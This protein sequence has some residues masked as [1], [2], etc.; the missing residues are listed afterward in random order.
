MTSSSASRSPHNQLL[1]AS[2]SHRSCSTPPSTHIPNPFTVVCWNACSLLAR[3]PAVQLYL[4]EYHPSIL[5]ILEPHIH[6]TNRIPLFPHYN[7]THQPHPRGHAT[8]GIVMYIHTS[9]TAA[10]YNVIPHAFTHDTSSFIL[11]YQISSPVLNRPF[12]LMPVYMSS[13]ATAADWINVKCAVDTAR[14]GLTEAMDIPFLLIGDMNARHPSWDPSCGHDINTSNTNGRHLHDTITGDHDWHLLNNDLS[15]PTPTHHHT[16]PP[17]TATII[18]LAITNNIGLFNHFHVDDGSTL[19]SDHRAIIVTVASRSHPTSLPTRYVWRTHDNDVPWMLFQLEL[20]ELLQTWRQRWEPMLSHTTPFTQ[21]DADNCWTQLRDMI[22]HAAHTTIGKKAIRHTSKHWFTIN[23]AIPG[24]YRTYI[25]LRRARDRI[26][27][28]NRPVP[29]HL[30]AQVRTARHTFR[31]AMRTAKQKCWE[32]L[33]EQVDRNHQ[34]IWTAWHRTT[35]ST[36]TP[37]PTFQPTANTQPP[38]SPVA[39]LN[40]LAQ[41]FQS[42]STLPNDPAFNRSQDDAVHNTVTSAQLPPVHVELPFTQQQLTDACE[43]INTN[44]ALGPDDISPCF[45]K[46]GGPALMSALFL[47][48]HICYQHGVLPSQWT[49]GLVIAL[50]KHKGDKHD[51]SNY[52]PI[53]ITSVIIRLLERLMLPTLKQYMHDHGIPSDLQFGFTALRSTYDAILR[54]LTAI[55]AHIWAYPIPVVFIDISKAYDR[56]WVHGLLHKLYTTANVRDHTY[57]F[58]RA[59]LSRRSFRVCGNGH[60]SDVHHTVDGVPQGSVSAPQLFIIY[61]HDIILAIASAYTTINKFA[62][63]IALWPVR[64]TLAQ[65]IGQVHTHM[66]NTLDHMT[67]WAST[68]KV[69]FSSLKTLM[70]I[71]WHNKSLPDSYRMPLCAATRPLPLHLSGFEI[72]RVDSYV[73]LGLTLFKTLSWEPH[74]NTIIRKATPTSNQITRLVSSSSRP[75]L[76]VI[77]NLV[78]AVLIP[79]LSYAMPF[80][81]LPAVDSKLEVALKQLIIKPLLRALGLPYTAHHNS[82]MLESRLMPLHWFQCYQSI[83]TAR[84]YIMLGDTPAE[85]QSRHSL[86][87]TAQASTLA[88]HHPLRTL[89]SH[90]KRLFSDTNP[91]T[92]QQL[93]SLS[94]KQIRHH[95]FNEFF[96]RWKV[97]HTHTLIGRQ[98]SLWACYNT[99]QTVDPTRLPSYLK[100]LGAQDA[101][102]MA[103]LRFNRAR[104]NQ[105][106]HKRA[107]SNTDKCPHC[108]SQVESPEHL[109]LHCPRYAKARYDCHTAISQHM[110]Y[111]L[112]LASLLASHERLLSTTSMCTAPVIKLLS[113]FINA[114]RQI[115]SM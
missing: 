91:P 103:R 50:Y 18:D 104:L 113:R 110:P 38:T 111:H 96:Q 27:G 108:P 12:L 82:V 112:S 33:I 67:T 39:N 70:V 48:F 32:E 3:A 24:L 37:L 95:V 16:S 2:N 72:E 31:E 1:T 11:A 92:L 53:T 15:V 98:H 58:Y 51:V 14:T 62:D 107:R 29:A 54:L 52:R 76:P 81:T 26:R 100:V 90:R 84:R 56:V 73:Y 41:H 74:I 59:L 10:L 86:I 45:I 40:I 88:I 63:D 30:S 87:F 21:Q 80:I 99:V 22:I 34:I 44:T 6:D 36:S 19:Y 43:H 97:D 71:F 20:T 25:H 64:A 69:T 55:G 7:V 42:V 79:K 93:Q 13:H 75:S 23:P 94:N 4:H 49:E 9:I 8:G 47:I 89:A 35:P 105:S 68:W 106:L 78:A 46:Q 28:R 65:G 115:R 83:T 85:K 114:I 102:H 66:Q 57:F 60:M 17:F 61:I 109:L 77:R 101:T 5:I